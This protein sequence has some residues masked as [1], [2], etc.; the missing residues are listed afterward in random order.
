MKTLVTAVFE[1]D[2]EN[3]YDTHGTPDMDAAVREH[4]SETT[5]DLFGYEWD[6]EDDVAYVEGP[7]KLIDLKLVDVEL[8]TIIKPLPFCEHCGEGHEEF[9]CEFDVDGTIWCLNCYLSNK[10]VH[11]HLYNYYYEMVKKAEIKYLKK[12]LKKLV[13]DKD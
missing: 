1:I 13:D 12:R 8:P 6:M 11:G 4:F 7:V 2:W 10:P 9:G 3:K 5:K